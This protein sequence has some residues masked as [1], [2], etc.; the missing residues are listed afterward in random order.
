MGTLGKTRCGTSF[1]SVGE[2]ETSTSPKSL[3]H[4]RIVALHLCGSMTKRT[5]RWQ[6]R[7]WMA[8]SSKGSGFALILPRPAAIP[9]MFHRERVRRP[10]EIMAGAMHLHEGL[11]A[12]R[13]EVAA[14]V[15]VVVGVPTHEDVIVA[16]GSVIGVSLR[17]SLHAHR[18]MSGGGGGEGLDPLAPK[19]W[20]PLL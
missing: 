5:R 11:L 20:L 9:A 2:L 19:Q 14:V 3:D 10:V 13:A 16:A 17:V 15:I 4:R 18:P 12:E 6:C 7:I 1:G 8:G